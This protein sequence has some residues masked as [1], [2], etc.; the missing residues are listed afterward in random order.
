M[1]DP[2]VAAVHRQSEIQR[3]EKAIQNYMGWEHIAPLTHEERDNMIR[4]VAR[5]AELEKSRPG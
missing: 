2:H 1:L 5:K 3:L 4:L